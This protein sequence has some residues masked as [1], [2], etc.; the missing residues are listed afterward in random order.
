[1]YIVER[2]YHPWK[3]SCIF[4]FLYP[5][6]KNIRGIIKKPTAPTPI[7]CDQHSQIIY[8]STL[9]DIPTYKAIKKGKYPVNLFF[10]C[11]HTTIKHHLV[12]PQRPKM[13]KVTK[14]PS[15]T[16][17]NHFFHKIYHKTNTKTPEIDKGW[18][19]WIIFGGVE[20]KKIW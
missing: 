17:E 13:S 9:R 10:T 19:I 11:H 20:Y 2:F 15:Q 6:T 7:I 16:W 14:I 4:S 12:P 8:V 3:F 5:L 1:M 18:R